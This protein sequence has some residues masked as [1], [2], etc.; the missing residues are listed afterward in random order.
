[1]P[2]MPRLRRAVAA[3]PP[4]PVQATAYPE[5]RTQQGTVP[6]TPESMKRVYYSRPPQQDVWNRT[7]FG[8][9]L[10]MDRIESALRGAQYGAMRDLCDLARETVATDPHLAAILQK[11]INAVAALP[12]D[13]VPAD[14]P[15]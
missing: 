10:N 3:T 15:G 14:G 7:R 1:M 4:A 8:R 9:S 13:I 2:T 6:I 5:T 11:R 12:F